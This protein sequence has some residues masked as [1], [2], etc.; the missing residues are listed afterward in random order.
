MEYIMGQ[1]YRH[2]QNNQWFLKYF[3]FTIFV[4]IH[5]GDSLLRGFNLKG[6][7]LLN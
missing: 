3:I 2:K 6:Q 1:P 7:Q 5:S 4:F